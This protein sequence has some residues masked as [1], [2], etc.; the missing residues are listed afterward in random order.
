MTARRS[1]QLRAPRLG[2][3][4]EIPHT[5]PQ[6]QSEERACG[7]KPHTRVS[8]RLGASRPVAVVSLRTDDP[9]PYRLPP[10]TGGLR[11]VSNHNLTRLETDFHSHRTDQ[12]Q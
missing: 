5:V 9:R 1:P 6:T 10:M 8:T 2:P 11:R 12:H 4:S 3:R 7:V